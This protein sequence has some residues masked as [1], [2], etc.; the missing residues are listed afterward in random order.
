MT[1]SAVIDVKMDGSILELKSFFK[2]LELSLFSNLDWGSFINSTATTV[3]KKIGTPIHSM[4][5]L[6]SEF[7][8]YLYKSS[9]QPCIKYSCHVWAGYLV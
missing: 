7:A 4:K 1:I 8:L 6:S 2:V 5:F 3:T 9:I